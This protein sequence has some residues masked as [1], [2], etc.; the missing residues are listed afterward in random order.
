[1]KL[2][3]PPPAHASRTPPPPGPTNNGTGLCTVNSAVGLS[4]VHEPQAFLAFHSFIE[5]GKYYVTLIIIRCAYSFQSLDKGQKPLPLF[6]LQSFPVSL[7]RQAIQLNPKQAILCSSL[8]CLPLLGYLSR[9]H[10]VTLFASFLPVKPDNGLGFCIFISPQPSNLRAYWREAVLQ[11]PVLAQLAQMKN[12]S[13]K[14]CESRLIKKGRAPAVCMDL[15]AASYQWPSMIEG[16][17]G[18]L[19]W[20]KGWNGRPWTCSASWT[21]CLP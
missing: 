13:L 17:I 18:Q 9:V 14:E 20:N 15:C 6:S 8:S 1:M 16:Q 12:A 11:V 21:T 4:L 7:T 2:S 10:S 19:E 3:L 5:M